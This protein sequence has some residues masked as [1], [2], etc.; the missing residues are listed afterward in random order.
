MG[1]VMAVGDLAALAGTI[2]EYE[3]LAADDQ[4]VKAASPLLKKF[5]ERMGLK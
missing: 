4:S 5:R 2:A 1:A 3:R